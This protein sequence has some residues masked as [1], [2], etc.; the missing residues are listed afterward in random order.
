MTCYHWFSPGEGQYCKLYHQKF[1]DIMLF[2]FMKWPRPPCFVSLANC[3]QP[4]LETSIWIINCGILIFK[5]LLFWRSKFSFY[6]FNSASYCWFSIILF[7][8]P[9]FADFASTG[10]EFSLGAQ[11][12]L[13]KQAFSKSLVN[14][15]IV[16]FRKS[17][18]C[19]HL[20]WSSKTF[21]FGRGNV[22][23]SKCWFI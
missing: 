13:W 3:P 7:S 9:E 16:A 11:L 2:L 20:F 10:K 12:D 19:E 22:A 21:S 1:Y 14:T 6:Y 5:G 15:I 4:V 8:W 18:S 17:R 23:V